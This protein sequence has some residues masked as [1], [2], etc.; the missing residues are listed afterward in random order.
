V[1]AIHDRI[2]GELRGSDGLNLEEIIDCA[3]DGLGERVTPK[4]W[5]DRIGEMGLHGYTVGEQSGV[6]FL[7]AERGTAA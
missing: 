1:S 6:Y 4:W 3:G 5:E 7:V 2:A